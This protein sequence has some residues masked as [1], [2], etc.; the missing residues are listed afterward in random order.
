MGMIYLLDTN[1]WIEYLNG[2]SPAIANRIST[3]RLSDLRLCSVVVAEL[4]FGA[5]KGSRTADN[6]RVLNQLQ[7]N[8]ISIPF[9]DSAAAVYGQVRA[10]LERS[11]TSIGPNDLMI[12]SIALANDL[13]LV[14]RNVREFSRV[15]SLKLE[16]WSTTP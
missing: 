11:G 3:T 4:A 8:F 12:A 1:A 2:R 9:D 13:T 15:P 14:T 5:H 6:L 16:N 10:H 7:S